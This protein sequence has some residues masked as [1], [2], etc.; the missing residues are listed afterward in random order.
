MPGLRAL[1]QASSP[2]FGTGFATP[3]ATQAQPQRNLSF[4]SAQP[5]FGL[6]LRASVQPIP[7]QAISDISSTAMSPTLPRPD[8]GETTTTSSAQRNDVLYIPRQPMGQTGEPDKAGQEGEASHKE[9]TEERSNFQ[10]E[11]GFS[12]KLTMT[13]CVHVCVCVCVCVR[14]ISIGIEW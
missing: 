8:L 9:N 7:S 4:G 3:L 6:N 5:S 12:G 10:V 1:Q 13:L 11:Q 14:H 2:A